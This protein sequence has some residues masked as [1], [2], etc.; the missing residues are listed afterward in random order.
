MNIGELA[1]KTG[2]AASKIRFYERIGLLKAVKRQANGYRH[3]SEEAIV[4]L[5]LIVAAQQAGFSL[6][7]LQTLVPADLSVWNHAELV[8]ALQQKI[9]GIEVM[10]QK[11]ANSKAQL[12]DLLF[13]IKAKPEDMDCA[14]NAK[15]VLAQFGLEAN[16]ATLNSPKA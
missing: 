12:Q 15:R 11:L 10:Q 6:E 7:E 3:Y 1:E 13:E 14:S 9:Q 5:K 8:T 4:Q 16:A 2:L